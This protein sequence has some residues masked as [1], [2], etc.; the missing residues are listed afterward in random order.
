MKKA[1][2]TLLFAFAATF[3]F[4]QL[5]MTLFDQVPYPQGLSSLWG[6]TDPDDGTEYALVGTR[7]GLSIVSLADPQNVVEVGFIPDN[8]SSWREVKAWGQYAYLV[9]ESTSPPS[10]VLI[11]DLHDAPNSFTATHWLPNIPGLGTL[12]RGHTLWIDESGYLYINGSNLNG[13]GVII[14]DLNPD[15]LN[16]TYVGKGPSEYVHD[17]Y[18]RGNF[19]FNS[20]IYEGHF[21]AFDITDKANPVLLA[22]QQTPANFTHN[23]WL[24]D[25]GDVLFTTDEV[26]DAPVT[27]Y[28]ISNLDNIVEL[29]QFQSISTM[30]QNVIPH[31]V[32][33]WNNWVI[34]AYYTNGCIIIDGARP[35]N[36]IEV[37][38][39]DTFIGGSGFNGVWGVFPYFAS[40]IVIASDM[41][42]GLFVFDVDYVRACWLEGTVTSAATGLPIFG[43]AVHIESTQANQ[44]STATNGGYQTGQ[45]IPGTFDVVFSAAG[46]F[47]KTVSATLENGV[48]TI[49]DVQLVPISSFAITG[50]TVKTAGGTPVAGAQVVLSSANGEFSTTSDASGNFTFPGVFGGEYTLYAGAWGYLHEVIENFVVNGN[51]PQPVVIT[52]DKGYQDDFILDLGWTETHTAST[53]WWVRGEPVGTD[54]NGAPSNTDTDVDGDLGN[55]CYVTGNGGGGAG[56]DDVDNGVVTLFSP[57]M[58]LSNYNQPKLSYS[59]WFFNDG[60]NGN[61]DDALQVRITNGTD[62][63]VLETITQ[64]NSAWNP[65]SEFDLTGLIALTNNMQVIFETS[66]LAS[67]GHL[68]EAAVDAF[69]VE[70]TSPYPAFQASATEGC[71]PFIVNFS[72]PSDSTATWAWTFEG[73]TPATSNL[74]NPPVTFDAPGTYSVSLTVV[75]NDGNT[76]TI[77]RPN[78]I[79]VNA[80]P[81]ASFSSNANGATIDFTNTSTGGGTYAWDFGDGTGTSTE[82]SP[83]Y[84]YGATGQYTVILTA[85]N[86]CGSS[87]ATVVVQVLAVPPTALFTADATAG[88]VPFEVQFTDL[89]GGA[90]DTWSWSFPGGTPATS[91]E[92]NP[93]VTYHEAGTYSVQ[94]TASNAAGSSQV[95]QSQ[96]IQVGN[97]PTVGFTFAI[98]EG[99]VTFT[100]TSQDATSYEWNFGDGS[101]STQANPVYSYGG[102]GSYEVT[103]SATNGCG[104]SVS[105]QTVVIELTATNDLDESTYVLTASPNPFREE[106]L[107]NYELRNNFS[108]ARLLVFNVPG[109]QIASYELNVANG[110][111]TLG[112]EI[113]QSGIYF[114]RLMVDGSM[115]KAL[116]VVK[117]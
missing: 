107:V 101:M 54:F 19:L 81:V 20:N 89:S 100:N 41:T 85:T 34:T 51:T 117:I 52:L 111:V 73:G 79:T 28:D 42:N 9:T 31:N 30:G 37:G 67:S 4:S 72:D 40:G 58:D 6:W 84:T 38:N 98:N 65:V 90:P 113:Q 87:T 23:T 7:T 24:N 76:Y 44:A 47:P 110:T 62:E 114:V 78:F 96:F 22:T 14:A 2:F 60:G 99:E 49:L 1:L 8:N 17:C 71:E 106:V 10:G 95:I 109:E 59:T 33:V 115:G 35:S 93:A 75:T 83:T 116:R 112:R 29:D 64:S 12:N 74:Q 68:V 32:H 43:A 26:S 88:C 15:P 94:L 103:L 70:D 82:Q 104:F 11:V 27:S 5:N 25:A 45:A 18:S 46:F 80:A 63:V 102:N 108:D 69:R 91:G 97:V 3:G 61:P 105:T 50:Q 13:G 48:L 57:V 55:Q 92:Q 56:T 36:L 53:G 16:P 77:D 39:F 21:S 86:D 66:D